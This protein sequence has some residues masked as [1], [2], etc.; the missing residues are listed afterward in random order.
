MIRFF[1]LANAIS[2]VALLSSASCMLLAMNGLF[3][4]AV[5]DGVVARKLTRTEEQQRFG[6]RLDSLVDGCSFGFAPVVLLYAAGLRQPFDVPLLGL[7]LVC[8]IWRLAYFD[9]VGLET[10]GSVR[11]FVGLPTT[12][13]ALIFP[14]GFL[15]ALIGTTWF[16]ITM[17][18]T[19]MVVAAALVSSLRVRKP[20]G[21]AYVF[22]LLLAIGVASVLIRFAPLLQSRLQ[23]W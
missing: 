6:G 15:T 14:L 18:I 2:L 8:A 3:A 16:L 11:Y 17:R 20:S 22:F 5:L 9:T 1:D 19:V 12:Y 13:V 23:M 4:F 7:F 10:Q 21:L